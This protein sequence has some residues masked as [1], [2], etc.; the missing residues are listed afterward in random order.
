MSVKKYDLTNITE[1]FILYSSSAPY[2]YQTNMFKI[3]EELVGDFILDDTTD[4]L[5]VMD[6]L[7]IISEF[8]NYH[9]NTS[10]KYKGH[11]R[12]MYYHPQYLIDYI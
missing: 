9:L 3:I 6:E 2:E 11:G 10:S 12:R 7:Q 4:K 8:K 1:K 5:D